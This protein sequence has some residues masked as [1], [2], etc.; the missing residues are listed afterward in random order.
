M[1]RPASGRSSPAMMRSSV[2][3]PEPEG[4]SSASNSPARMSSVKSRSTAA[5]S[6][7]FETDSTLIA[8]ALP[9]GLVTSCARRDV[10]GV[11][12]FEDGFDDEGD[13]SEAGKEGGDGERGN[14]VV[15]I[16]EDLHVQRERV[17][18]SADVA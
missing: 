7:V 10:V 17:G 4:P 8:V 13:K 18:Q 11:A 1:M 16:V 12:P 15:L 2:V 14:E 5:V 3:L 6:K 9:I